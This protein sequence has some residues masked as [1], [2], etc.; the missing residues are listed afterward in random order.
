[1]G[2]VAAPFVLA[3]FLS[4]GDIHAFRSGLLS[5]SFTAA[6]VALLTYPLYYEITF[7]ELQVRCGI[8]INKEIPL[9]AIEEVFPTRNP[10]SAP[11]WSLDRLQVNYRDGGRL[12]SI[13]I[14]PEAKESFLME[15]VTSASGLRMENGRAVR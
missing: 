13:L 14:S 1:M 9:S 8:L 2:A 3:I 4:P 5:S 12:R 7:S 11:A 6:L 10:V 15:L